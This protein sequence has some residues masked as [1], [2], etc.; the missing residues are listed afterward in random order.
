MTA[1]VQMAP[2]VHIDDYY[3]LRLYEMVPGRTPDLH[4]RMSVEVPPLFARH[5]IPRP[6]AYWDGFAGPINPL[7]AYLL[8]WQNLDARM[9]AW[10]AFYA[11]P[12]WI[13]IRDGSNAGRQMVDT[14]HIFILRP[15]PAWEPWRTPAAAG[16]VGGIHELR[17][18]Q[19]LNDDPARAHAALAEI[20][21]PFL[22]ARGAVVLGVFA[23]WYGTRLPQAVTL[24]AWPDMDTRQRAM[25]AYD[26]DPGILAARARE[27]DDN[28]RPIFLRCDTHLMRP[29]PYGT[30]QAGLAPL[31]D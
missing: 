16:P 20:D 30:A 31:P 28:R 22:T 15:S 14:T 10:N 25:D 26:T 21:L 4:H 23:G 12:E 24:L 13:E 19:V 11:D 3:E 29:A 7:Y 17:L 27:R 5:G 1:P 18:H 6:L 9:A 8:R 2:E